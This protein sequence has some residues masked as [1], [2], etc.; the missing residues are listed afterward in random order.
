[1]DFNLPSD[2]S[3]SQLEKSKFGVL[4][5]GFE[6]LG[7]ELDSCGRTTRNAYRPIYSLSLWAGE[8]LY[9]LQFQLSCYDLMIWWERTK[10]YL[11]FFGVALSMSCILCQGSLV[12][13]VVGYGSS[14]SKAEVCW[15][16]RRVQGPG[17]TSAWTGTSAHIVQ[18]C[19]EAVSHLLLGSGN[20]RWVFPDRQVGH[21]GALLF[22]W[23]SVTPP[24][25]ELRC[26]G[27]CNLPL[28]QTGLVPHASFY[29]LEHTA[30]C[31]MSHFS[32]VFPV[33]IF[34][35]RVPSCS[36]FRC[37]RTVPFSH[38]PRHFPSSIPMKSLFVFLPQ[39]IRVK[40]PLDD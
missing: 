22:D 36:A 33:T 40:L 28:C 24:S 16:S 32:K 18:H 4:V 27:C 12:V 37:C 13:C 3:V 10:E 11:F 26:G 7:L 2:C 29:C 6:K 19:Q 34:M 30:Y 38:Q 35:S 5:Q 23:T 8:W 1:V 25:T 17:A 14:Q 15:T 21:V 9:K 39:N 20:W 31:E